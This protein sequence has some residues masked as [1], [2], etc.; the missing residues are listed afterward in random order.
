V[1]RKFFP[2]GYGDFPDAEACRTRIAEG[3]SRNE[4]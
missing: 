1:L 4:P 3:R 2:T